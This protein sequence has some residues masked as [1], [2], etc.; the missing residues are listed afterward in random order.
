MKVFETGK[1]HCV[2]KIEDSGKHGYAVRH[3]DH[4]EVNEYETVA[5]FDAIKAAKLYESYLEQSY[6][7]VAPATWGQPKPQ[8]PAVDF[9]KAN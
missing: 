9:S 8:N 4:P 5:L 2:V 7:F 6:D 3:V 1:T